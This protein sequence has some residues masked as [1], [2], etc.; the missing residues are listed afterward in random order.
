MKSKM[1]VLVSSVCIIFVLCSPGI[2][3]TSNTGSETTNGITIVSLKNSISGMTQSGLKATLFDSGYKALNMVG[4]TQTKTVD[5]SGRFEF[6]NLP[7]SRYN[8]LVNNSQSDSACFISDISVIAS[9]TIPDTIS[10]SIFPTGTI[11]G[12]ALN[13][14]NQRLDSVVAY[15]NGSSFYDSSD[16]AGSYQISSIPRGNYTIDFIRI[17]E[18]SWEDDTLTAELNDISVISGEDTELDDVI[19]DGK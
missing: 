18:T 1:I 9:D 10:D 2:N 5:D 17:Y 6:T 19:L 15:I 4:F 14:L 11:S 8:I 7:T 13:K 12:T 3:N 16:N